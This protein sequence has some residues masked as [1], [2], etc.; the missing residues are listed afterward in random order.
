MTRRAFCQKVLLQVP[1]LSLTAPLRAREE[2][3]TQAVCCLLDASMSMRLGY[4]FFDL[5]KSARATVLRDPCVKQRLLGPEGERSAFALIMWASANRQ[6]VAIPWI[7]FREEQ[8][9]ARLA[10]R[11]DHI[12][13]PYTNLEQNQTALGMALLVGIE[14]MSETPV[15]YAS[16][17]ILNVSSNGKNN[18]GLDPKILRERMI[19]ESINVNAIIMPGK[20]PT[21][22]IDDLAFYYRQNIITGGLLVPVEPGPGAYRRFVDGMV[23]KFCSELV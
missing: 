16:N 19:R 20:A 14:Y 21:F 6:I 22:T 9:F 12:A 17:K 1:L 18:D 4:N 10:K 23:S 3:V 15:R 5:Q 7:V 11:I 8:D 2:K 13:W